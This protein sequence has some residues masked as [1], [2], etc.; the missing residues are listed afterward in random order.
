MI[1]DEKDYI[2]PDPLVWLQRLYDVVDRSQF[3]KRQKEIINESL[4][5]MEEHLIF[6]R[7][8]ATQ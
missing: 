4:L 8:G 1:M 3:T 2:G 6:H 7:D 5:F